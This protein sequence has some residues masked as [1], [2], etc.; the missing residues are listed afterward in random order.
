MQNELDL[1]APKCP[2]CGRTDFPHWSACKRH[3]KYCAAGPNA[4]G[5]RNVKPNRAPV[6]SA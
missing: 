4:R 1:V 2:H 5:K 3:V 6:A